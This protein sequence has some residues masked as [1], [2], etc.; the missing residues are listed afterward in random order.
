M[1]LTRSEVLGYFPDLNERLGSGKVTNVMIDR[2]ITDA[3]SIIDAYLSRR[4][5][6][7][8]SSVSPLIQTICKELVEYFDCK[9]RYTPSYGGE[10][11]AEKWLDKR[12]ERMIRLLE[13]IASGQIS[14]Y[15]SEGSLIEPDSV[16][17]ISPTSNNQNIDPIFKIT[18]EPVEW[19]VPDGYSGEK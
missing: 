7:P 14:L 3:S 8:L 19:E 16:K 13:M 6:V 18:K 11:E 1:Y 9:N 15:D 2:W 10:T 5:K 17:L 12:Y 4:Y